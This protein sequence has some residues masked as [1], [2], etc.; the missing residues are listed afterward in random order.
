MTDPQKALPPSRDSALR[1][2]A[3]GAVL[4]VVAIVAILLLGPGR[5]GGPAPSGT[6][7][8]GSLIAGGSSGSPTGARGSTSSRPSGPGSGSAS[9]ARPT[10]KPTSPSTV[11]PTSRPTA[12]PTAKPTSGP[13]TQP[14]IG[15]VQHVIWLWLE[16]H[17]ASAVTPASMPYL[18]SLGSTYGLATD[19]SAVTHPSLPNYIA[20]TSGGTQGIR[21]DRTHDLS[22]ASIFSQLGTAAHSYE[23]DYPGGCFTGSSSPGGIDG[24]GVAGTYV[25]KHDPA[26][27]YTAISRTSLCSATISNL[28]SFSNTHRFAFVTPNLC[29]DAHDCSL[30]IADTFLRGFVPQVT[31]SAAFAH[32]LLVITFDEGSGSQVVYTALIA[33][34]LHGFRTSAS[35]DH[36]SLLATTEH[37]L[38]LGYL[39]A[40]RGAR[41]IPLG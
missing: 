17:S 37:L 10:T 4:V 13:T 31:G 25:R 34:W 2:I 22:V 41:L 6:L 26:I 35:L 1:P 9:T 30:Q 3:I 23:Q 12:R 16:N 32:T 7:P 36:Y 5:A 18:T 27:S 11:G 29:N 33:P 15:G 21:D 20:A 19:Y 8:T 40:A 39:G 28:A 24:P 38:G 14:G